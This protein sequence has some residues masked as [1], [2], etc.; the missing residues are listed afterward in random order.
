MSRHRRRLDLGHRCGLYP[1]TFKPLLVRGEPGVGEVS[2]SRCGRSPW[3][4]FVSWPVDSRTETRDSLL[5]RGLVVARRK[6]SYGAQRD[7][8][9]PPLRAKLAIGEFV[10]PGPLWWAFDGDSAHKQAERIPDHAAVHA[11]DLEAR[12]RVVVLIDEIDKADP[13]SQR[14]ARRIGHGRF[15]VPWLP[16]RA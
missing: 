9:T 5:D 3:A 11:R 8:R 13:R 14:L 15:D 16:A 6:R 12:A 4:A 2:R 10:H 1:A 7:A